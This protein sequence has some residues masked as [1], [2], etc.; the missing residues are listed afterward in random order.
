MPVTFLA[1][2]SPGLGLLQGNAQRHSAEPSDL[3]VHTA[4]AAME[5]GIRWYKSKYLR[6]SGQKAYKKGGFQLG[7]RNTK[8]N[9]NIHKN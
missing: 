6:N 9:A 4:T 5:R 2:P 8:K 3:L 7:Y 1:H